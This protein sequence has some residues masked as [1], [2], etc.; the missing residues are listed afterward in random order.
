MTEQQDQL[1][2]AAARAAVELVED[3]MLLGLGTGSTAALFIDFLGERVRAGLQVTAIATSRRSH[4]QASALGIPMLEELR[5]PLD[6][7]VDGADEIDPDLNLL[8]GRGGALVREKLVAV[9]A[10]RFV[11]IADEGKLVDR[12]GAGEGVVPVEVLPFLW[13]ET[14][15]RLEALAPLNWTLRGGLQSPFVSDNG[16]L[17]VDLQIPGGLEEPAAFGAQLKAVTGVVE[18][19][20][21]PGLTTAC[22]VAGAA[23]VRVMGDL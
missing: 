2:A 5:T 9:A 23:G 10:R 13:S 20:I 4:E 22:L 6:L 17:V 16:N 3:G 18:H 1:K 19:G 21:F 12:L 14:V 15:R 8:K 7:A 11:V